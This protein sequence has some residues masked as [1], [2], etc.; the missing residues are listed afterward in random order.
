MA[1]RRPKIQ[2]HSKDRELNHPGVIH[3]VTVI[4]NHHH[5]KIKKKF[6]KNKITNLQEQICTHL[7][8]AITKSVNCDSA[9][10]A[11]AV[12]AGFTGCSCST[13][14]LHIDNSF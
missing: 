2:R 4:L 9:K 5:R 13:N 8:N 12:P 1:P 14:R 7:Q 3:T 6:F 11:A 10:A